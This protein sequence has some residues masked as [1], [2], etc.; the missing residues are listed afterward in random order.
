MKAEVVPLLL[1][2][3]PAAHARRRT[4]HTA[5]WGETQIQEAITAV[6][7][8]LP[9]GVTLAYL[10]S[11]GTVRVRI[12]VAGGE[13][14]NMESVLERVDKDIRQCLPSDIIFGLDETDLVA[15]T[16]D[17]LLASNATVSTA[18]SCTGGKVA[19]M[20]IE[21]A[22]ASG[23]YLGGA[24]AYDNAV[25]TEMLGVNPGT[26]RKHGAVSEQT[27]REMVAGALKTFGSTYA[28]ATS[29]IAGPGG[30]TPQKPVGTIWLAV[31]DAN[32]TQTRLLSLARDRSTNIEYT[33][34]AAVDALRR[35]VLQA[36]L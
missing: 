35:F 30:G 14:M 15:A 25:K 29:G 17:L 23:F 8:S 36:G 12:T 31:G 19:H 33:A 13:L 7:S 28:I 10:P 6:E 32:S 22:G 27:V 24:V 9:D 21:R 20:L 2:T 1:K 3:F 16:H 18:E 11:L 34:V 5:G 26:I 4:I